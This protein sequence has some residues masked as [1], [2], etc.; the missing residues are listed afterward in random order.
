M[1]MVTIIVD[2]PPLQ[3]FT[4]QGN[5]TA[6]DDNMVTLRANNQHAIEAGMTVVSDQLDSSLWQVR[7]QEVHGQTITLINQSHAEG[8]QQHIQT[9]AIEQLHFYNEN[10]QN[11]LR[12]AETW[13]LINIQ[14]GSHELRVH[15]ALLTDCTCYQANTTK[16]NC[17]ARCTE[18][19]QSNTRR[20]LPWTRN[21]TS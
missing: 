10:N 11:A 1:D 6:L 9:V 12:D 20:L 3:T 2:R 4:V 7:V 8:F 19:F 5:V 14:M 13:Q 21:S 17:S 18:I 15:W 16:S